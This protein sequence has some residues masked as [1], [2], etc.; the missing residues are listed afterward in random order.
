MWLSHDY[1]QQFAVQET[2]LRQRAQTQSYSQDNLF[3]TILGMLNVTTN[4][5]QPEWNILKGCRNRTV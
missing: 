2:C 1:Q 5:Y 3:H 4:E